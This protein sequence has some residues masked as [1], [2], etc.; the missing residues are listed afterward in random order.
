MTASDDEM[1][2][3]LALVGLALR[4]AEPVPEH[5]LVGARAACT[6]RTID[7]E[8]AELV[9]DSALETTGVRGEDTARQLTFRAP[10]VEIEVMVV[11]GTTRRIVGQLIPPSEL[12]VQLTTGDQVAEQ[13]SDRMGRFAFDD[14]EP[15]PIRLTVL[16]ADG[17]QTIATEWV[18]L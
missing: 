16:D 11:D 5:V 13:N 18:L 14:V 6:W 2:D 10:G 17:T 8:L 3:L 12:I 1:L 7:A 15:G 4:A 9:F